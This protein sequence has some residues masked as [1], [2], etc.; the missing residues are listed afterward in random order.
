[1][2]EELSPIDLDI[3]VLWSK[4]GLINCVLGIN[5]ILPIQSIDWLNT[6]TNTDKKILGEEMQQSIFLIEINLH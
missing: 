2:L 6:E 3:K 1:M 4:I 5:L